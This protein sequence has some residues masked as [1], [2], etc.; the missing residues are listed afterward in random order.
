MATFRDKDMRDF[1][2]TS[3]QKN[4]RSTDFNKIKVGNK[5][6]ANDVVATALLNKNRSLKFTKTGI[7][8]IML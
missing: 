1:R 2:I 6:L 5:V 4:S 8:T 7:I 3:Q